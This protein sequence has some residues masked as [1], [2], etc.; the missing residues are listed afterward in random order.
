VGRGRQGATRP[1]GEPHDTDEGG[2]GR[3]W[4]RGG[5][6]P[7]CS[8]KRRPT[9]GDEPFS[10]PL[11]P[12]P[13]T[14]SLRRSQRDKRR[15]MCGHHPEPTLTLTLSVTLL[16][17]YPSPS[18]PLTRT[19]HSLVFAH[20][21][22]PWAGFRGAHPHPR[23]NAR[24]KLQVSHSGEDLGENSGAL[25]GLGVRRYPPESLSSRPS[26]SPHLTHP[27]GAWRAA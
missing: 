22:A 20:C 21:V 18:P 23:R 6:E 8:A 9:W 7:S 12:D 13:H 1:R 27:A 10:G 19:A 16:R 11:P 5:I 25:F 17:P 24:R 2:Q 4:R 26:S 3:G 14:L 15:K